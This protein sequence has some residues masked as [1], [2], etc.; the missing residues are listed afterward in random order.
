M[1]NFFKKKKKKKKSIN[2]FKPLIDLLKQNKETVNII[3]KQNIDGF[4]LKL[5]DKVLT[6]SNECDSY[7][8]GEIVEFWDN[9]GK[10]SNCIPQ[11]KD[12]NGD[13]WSVMG[14]I[15]P[16]TEELENKIK[17]LRPLEQW[18]YFVDKPYRY[19]EKEIIKK[20]LKYNS[21]QKI[22]KKFV[23]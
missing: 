21:I 20:E 22:K 15:R 4:L 6:K 23:N 18:N 2:N 9:D 7:M 3:K 11:V 13:I 17:D 16:Y 19:T 14:I 8:V 12:S 10:W 5:G 1:F